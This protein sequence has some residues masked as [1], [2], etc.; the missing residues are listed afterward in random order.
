MWCNNNVIKNYKT[1]FRSNEIFIFIQKL[2][3]YLNP[4]KS[5]YLF[6]YKLT[7]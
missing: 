1:S 3:I 4:D 7:T 5:F 6:F 2:F